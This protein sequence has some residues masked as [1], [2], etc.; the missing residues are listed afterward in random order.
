MKFAYHTNTWGGVVGNPGG[1]TSVKD[2]YFLANGNTEDALIDLNVIDYNGFELFD[3]N[4]MALQEHELKQLLEKYLLEFV[5]VYTGANFIYQDI[6]NDE[7]LKIE[8]VIKKASYFGCKN[9]V[10]GGGALRNEGVK[11]DDYKR[12]GDSL[13]ELKYLSESHGLVPHYHPHLGSMVET[14]AQI[15]QL[16]EHTDIYFCPDTAHLELG[17]GD[18]LQLIQKYSHL[19]SYV[20]LKDQKNGEFLPL[21]EGEQNMI[22]MLNVISSMKDIEWIAVELDSYYDP[23]KGAQISK[24]FLEKHLGDQEL[25]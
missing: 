14:P 17:G 12:L 7:L 11:E 10:I 4:L 22:R 13:N 25:G 23:K 8:N 18:P 20:H 24:Q 15:E 16:Y 5:G 9:I 1:V 2:A 3:G 6:K 21:G 19:I